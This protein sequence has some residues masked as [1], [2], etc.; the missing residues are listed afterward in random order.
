MTK[1][2]HDNP[3]SGS[4]RQV[5]LNTAEMR[6]ILGSSFIGSAIEFYDFILY[7]T[8]SSIVFPKLFFTDLGPGL[9]LVAAFATLA[10]GY[11]ARPL[12]GV[13]FG[14]FGDRYGRK[15][16][17]VV[18]MLVMGGVTVAIG[19]MPAT[20]KIG[21]IAPV[22]LLILRILQGIAVGGEWGGAALMAVEHAP[23]NRRGFAAAFANAGGPAGAVLATLVL[24]LMTVLTGSQF[25]VWGWRIPFVLSALLIVVGLV[26]RLKVSE[27]PAFQA[28]Q[29]ASDERRMPIVDVL[30]NHRGAVMAAL[31]VTISVYT[32]QAIVTVWGVA[33]AVEAG[34]DKTAIL[35]W[36]ATA[37]VVTVIVTFASARVSDRVGQRRALV[38]GCSVAAVSAI[39]LTFMIGSGSLGHYAVAIML[40]NGVVQGLIYGPIAAYV[41]SLFP[42][43][44]RYTGASIG[45]QGAAALGAGVTPVVASALVLLPGGLL[46]VGT[47]WA[48]MAVVSAT[49]AARYRRH[50]VEEAAP[51]T[52][53]SAASTA[54]AATR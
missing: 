37:A 4:G 6:R 40:G 17:L 34:E 54:I 26:V 18:S 12:G 53:L 30:R 52:E 5:S 13:I 8:A 15:K 43:D 32:T 25:A 38:F 10:A 36:K 11:F 1:T 19:L 50:T 35:N 51:V 27:T 44:V 9:G 49:V 14:H 46:W 16:A 20:A 29:K 23:K 47:A 45:Y 42:A 31:L 3:A 48:A 7:A 39:P 28:L 22:A 24:S 33:M 21:I 2:H 41:T